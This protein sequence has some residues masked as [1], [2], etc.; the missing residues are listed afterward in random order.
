MLIIESLKAQKIMRKNIH[1][2]PLKLNHLV[3]LIVYCIPSY[4]PYIA[5]KLF[6]Y[7]WL[8]SS[9]LLS[10]VLLS[11]VSVNCGQP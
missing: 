10:E 2:L 8:Y 11:S 1:V 9:L 4:L 3:A 6:T 5:V 7:L